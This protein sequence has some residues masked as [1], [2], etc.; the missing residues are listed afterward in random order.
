M[1]TISANVERGCSYKNFFTRKFIVRKFLYTKISRSTI[2]INICICKGIL[3]HTKI[4]GIVPSFA[5]PWEVHNDYNLALPAFQ[6]CWV[7][8]SVYNMWIMYYLYRLLVAKLWQRRMRGRH[9]PHLVA[10]KIESLKMTS[11]TGYREWGW[12]LQPRI[13]QSLL[14][15]WL[16]HTWPGTWKFNRLVFC[17]Q[18]QT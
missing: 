1:R 17:Y 12:C 10:V 6:Y 8:H 4:I 16:T 5:I 13:Q 2:I 11:T 14:G 18:S 15:G 9:R 3:Y 7:Q